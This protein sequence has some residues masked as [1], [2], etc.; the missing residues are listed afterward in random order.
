MV[1]AVRYHGT[2]H[3]LVFGWY[4]PVKGLQRTKEC[5][6]KCFFQHLD[7]VNYLIHTEERD[8]K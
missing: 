8:S 5:I 7:M 6:C 4:N 3:D 2:I 1:T